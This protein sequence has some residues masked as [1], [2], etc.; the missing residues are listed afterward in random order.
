[1]KHKL[2]KKKSSQ[3]LDLK[4][5]VQERKKTVAENRGRVDKKYQA[6]NLLKAR[7]EERKERGKN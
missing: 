1:M 7:R 6:M 2:T 3:P 5:R 4:E